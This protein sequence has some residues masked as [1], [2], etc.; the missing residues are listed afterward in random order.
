M[1]GLALFPGSFDPFTKGH[2]DIVGRALEL[3][4]EVIIG[5]G[6]NEQKEGW[7]PVEERVASIKKLYTDKKVRTGKLRF[8]VLDKIG[9]VKEFS[10]NVFST[11]VEESLAGKIIMDM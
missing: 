10:E 4:D 8:V 7:M 3:F 1:R 2:A 9:S 6:Y 5:V 11:E